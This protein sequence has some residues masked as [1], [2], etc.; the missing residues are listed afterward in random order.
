MFIFSIILAIAGI[1][2]TI[3]LFVMD[4]SRAKEGGSKKIG[5]VLSLVI[6]LTGILLSVNNLPVPYFF[7]NDYE[8]PHEGPYELK[9]GMG[10]E[11]EYLG[12]A[13]K[14]FYNIDGDVLPS[15]FGYLY[16]ESLL[17]EESCT[18]VAQSRLGAFWSD[19]VSTY[20]QID[21]VHAS[22]DTV[23]E[24][25]EAPAVRQT[26]TPMPISTSA[27][28]AASISNLNPT[29]VPTSAP[30]PISTSASTAAPTPNPTPAP[31]AAPTPDPTQ[32][33]VA[34]DFSVSVS[35][36]K[37][38]LQVSQKGIDVMITATTSLPASEITVSS[39]TETSTYGPYNMWQLDGSWF[40][41]ANFY[42][43]GT[44]TV[45]I[46]AKTADGQTAT[47]SFIYTYP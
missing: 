23:S 28:T 2:A 16:E 5:A 7:P 35:Y 30:T 1:T 25:A 47:D 6:G 17:I 45:V 46:T 13:L 43:E 12:G 36:E 10:S 33:P 8:Q 22:G 31:T 14:I 3:I 26:A 15:Q 9:I 39:S 24:S 11:L 20:I 32:M 34:S 38:P 18:V 29:P 44:F 42:E 37:S 41:C 4:W 19:P 40:F 27:L 21:T